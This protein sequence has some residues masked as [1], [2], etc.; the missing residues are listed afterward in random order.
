MELV[1]GDTHI[2][3]ERG[4]WFIAENRA[5]LEG[6]R[7]IRDGEIVPACEQSCPA[8]AIVFGNIR[9]PNTRVS[10]AVAS[11]RT[12]RVLDAIVNTQPAVN[13][14]RK[15]TFHEVAAGEH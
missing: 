5:V 1:Q 9:D 10:E 13:Y 14:L 7:P 4:E 2:F 15:V 12:Y 3:A 6:R 11:S 8:E